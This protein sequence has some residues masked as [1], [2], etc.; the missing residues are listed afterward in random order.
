MPQLKIQ[1]VKDALDTA[2]TELNDKFSGLVEEVK[3]VLSDAG[4]GTDTGDCYVAT[5]T[6]NTELIELRNEV[7]ELREAIV[8]HINLYNNHI[9]QQHNKKR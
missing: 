6:D 8:G 2:K 9:V 4:V 1:D 3:T 7:A 5:P